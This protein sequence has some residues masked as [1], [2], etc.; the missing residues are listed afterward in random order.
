MAAEEGLP[1]AQFMLGWY[2]RNGQGVELDVDQAVHWYLLAAEQ[3]YSFALNN[4]GVIYE[5]DVEGVPRDI[6]KSFQY[7]GQAV[8]LGNQRALGNLSDLIK[9]KLNTL[10][11]EP[12]TH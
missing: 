1:R 12:I 3:G 7:Y 10:L 6:S 2:Y 8:E 4:L 5:D 9:Y 11:A